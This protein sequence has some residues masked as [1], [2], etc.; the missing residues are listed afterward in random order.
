MLKLTQFSHSFRHAT[1][2]AFPRWVP[3][4][5]PVMRQCFFVCIPKDPKCRAFKLCFSERSVFFTVLRYFNFGQTPLQSVLCYSHNFN[6]LCYFVVIIYFLFY[7]FMAN[8]YFTRFGDLSSPNLAK[9]PA[10]RHFSLAIRSPISAT[11]VHYLL[12][13]YT[14]VNPF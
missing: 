11:F 8:I 9:R 5:L 12:R 1:E 10:Q 6:C 2:R 3:R 14:Y 13:I 7:I 4:L